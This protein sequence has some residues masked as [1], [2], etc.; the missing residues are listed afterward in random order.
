MK[1]DV[2]MALYHQVLHAAE[3]AILAAQQT[4]IQN[5]NRASMELYWA[6]GELLAHTAERYQWGQNILGRLSKDLSK[7][8]SS[9]RG[10]SEQNLR[11]MRQ[12]YNE[13]VQAPELLELAKN[14]RW[15]TNIAILHKVKTWE[16]RRFYLEMASQSLCSRDI[17]ELQIKSQAY[18][19]ERLLPKKH[20]FDTSL[21][22]T[23]AAKA[24][25]LLKPSYFF[26]V[27]Q[28]FI[29]SKSLLEKQIETEMVSRIKDV[30][31]MLGKGFAFMGN[32]YRIVIL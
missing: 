7:S 5:A 9:A 10:Y 27:S 13:Y 30:I 32:Q 24:D 22:A 19:R 23:L 2:E 17:I 1:N 26:E 12:F 28:P 3:Q 15:G 16:A 20:N 25:N 14:V 8:F 31:M 6:L 4:F 21:S 11:R 18:E 29:G